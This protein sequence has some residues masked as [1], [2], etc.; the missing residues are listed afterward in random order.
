MSKVSVPAR[1]FFPVLTT[2]ESRANDDGTPGKPKYSVQLVI[3]K[4]DTATIARIREA[5]KAFADETFGKGAKGLRSIIQDGDASD[6]D[7]Y[8]ER[9]G[10]WTMN[11]SANAPFPPAIYG[12]D[13]EP[14]DRDDPADLAEIANQFYRGAN[15]VASIN[16]FELKAGGRGVS[17]GLRAILRKPG[18]ERVG[19]NYT[20]VTGVE[21]EFGEFA[22]LA[23]AD[24][25]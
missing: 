24:L 5:E 18:G 14:L 4:T 19:G 12:L 8:P 23:D 16:P 1:I 15:V 10:C 3:P 20:P 13:R 11:V 25:L 9:V 17:F 2:P 22:A 7:K 21:D 6:T